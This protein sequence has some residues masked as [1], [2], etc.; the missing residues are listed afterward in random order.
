MFSINS[1]EAGP[2]VAP[3]TEELN[4]PFGKF[5]IAKQGEFGFRKII[6]DSGVLPLEYTCDFTTPQTARFARDKFI[7]ELEDAQQEDA[8]KRESNMEQDGRPKRRVRHLP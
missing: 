4:T 6:W 7:K 8:R 3:T 2:R 1:R 5:T